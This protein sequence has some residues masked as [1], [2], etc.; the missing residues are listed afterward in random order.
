LDRNHCLRALDRLYN[1]AILKWYDEMQTELI[2]ETTKPQAREP[3]HQ[4]LVGARLFHLLRLIRESGL[5]IYERELGY[6]EIHRQLIIMIGVSGGLSSHEIVTLTGHEKAQV[7]RAI[8]PLEEEG[9]IGR[10]RLRAKLTLL[11]AGRRIFDRMTAIMRG[12][13]ATLTA[14]ISSADLKRF[15]A[16]TEQLTAKAAQLYADERRL[17]TEAGVIACTSSGPPNWP[18]TSKPPSTMITPKIISLVAYLKRSAMLAYQR[19]HGLSHFQWQVLSMIGEAP[20]VPLARLIL[21]MSRDKSQVGRTVGALEQAGLITR[22]RPTRR[23]D[24]LLE[25]TAKGAA[26][27]ESMY[28]LA[29]RREEALFSDF[30]ADDRAFYTTLIGTLTDNARDMLEK[31]EAAA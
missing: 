20:P 17:S 9:L 7:S 30:D 23:R 18:G 28:D 25:P 5:P 24:I 31:A 26:A 10:E 8:K 6:K 22:S 14:G 3:M 12:R 4:R 16:M 1:V 15:A 13:D 11:P 21:T 2:D 19:T 29:L 27:F